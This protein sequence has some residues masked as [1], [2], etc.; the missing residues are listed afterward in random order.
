M[1]FY[2]FSPI[3]RKRRAGLCS[4]LEQVPGLFDPRW[5]HFAA[6]PARPPA[7]FPKKRLL[8]L[9]P[10]VRAPVARFR[11]ECLRAQI[12]RQTE[13]GLP[14]RLRLKS[15]LP[16]EKFSFAS[17]RQLGKDLRHVGA[18]YLIALGQETENF[19]ALVV[20]LLDDTPLR[21]LQIYSRFCAKTSASILPHPLRFLERLNRSGTCADAGSDLI[22]RPV[23]GTSASGQDYA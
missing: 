21:D 12:H 4:P 17:C 9:A 18:T 8:Q 23:V 19:I 16:I 14:R 22:Y 6:G 15:F 10:D 7:P 3:G 5:A 13:F 1:A 20:L 11:P 2:I